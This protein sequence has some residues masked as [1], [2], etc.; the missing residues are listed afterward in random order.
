MTI[1]ITI[2]TR[3]DIATPCCRPSAGSE[4]AAP[5]ASSD[6]ANIQIGAVVVCASVIH[7]F[8]STGRRMRRAIAPYEALLILPDGQ[9]S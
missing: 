9:I 4:I 7:K 8:I 6:S 1:H 2:P 3:I 5:D